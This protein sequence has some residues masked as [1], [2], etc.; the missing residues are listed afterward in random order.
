MPYKEILSAVAIVVTFVA[1]LPYIR[2][3]VQGQTKPHVFSWIIWS[4]TTFII[5]AAQLAD[6][7][8]VGAWP[9]GVS[10]CITLYV[11]VLS[12]RKKS[13]ITITKSDWLFL[14]MA[15]ATLPLWY[16]TSD[17]LLVVIILT[18]V[19]ILG[20]AP[21]FR[22]AYFSPY[23]EQLK[24]YAMMAVRDLIAISAMEHYSLTTI[25]FPIVMSTSCWIFIAMVLY[26]RHLEGG[27]EI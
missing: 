13:D 3:I 18:T 21:T 14:I 7:G 1:F 5:F 2:S 26:R 11:A 12:Y 22:K 10:S 17:P 23:G 19:D 6:K 8:G 15:M 25:L 20:F 4:S 27:H 16:F 24:F 9:L